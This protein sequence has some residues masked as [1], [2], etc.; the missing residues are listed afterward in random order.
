M[1]LEAIE[2][3]LRTNKA[4]SQEVPKGLHIEHIMPQKWHD[5]WPLAGEASEEARAERDRTVHSIGNLTLVNNRLNA[6][7][8]N[9]P[10]GE[11]RTTLDAH[12]VLHLNRR[13][14]SKGPDVWDEAAI[15]KRA[16]WLHKQAV[17]VWP[18][19]NDINVE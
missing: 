14:V 11:K 18:Q 19:S 8:S 13:L 16:R 17:R 10:W 9:A 1:V 3:Q 7:L 5:N 2:G 4:E 12:S 15:E 6:A